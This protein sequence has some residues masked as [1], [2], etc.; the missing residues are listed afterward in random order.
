MKTTGVVRAKLVD[1]RRLPECP[2]CHGGA[3][4]TC[5]CRL[6]VKIDDMVVELSEQHE[7]EILRHGVRPGQTC[8]LQCEDGV[9]NDMVHSKQGTFA[10]IEEMFPKAR[11]EAGGRLDHA[12]GISV[13]VDYGLDFTEQGQ[14][15]AQGWFDAQPAALP[16]S[17]FPWGEVYRN[18]DGTADDGDAGKEEA[19]SKVFQLAGASLVP[20][21]GWVLE[22]VISPG[23]GIQWPRA[24]S[25]LVKTTLVQYFLS[26]SAVE[27]DSLSHL[28][29]IVGVSK[30]RISPLWQEF[31]TRFPGVKAR[32]EKTDKAKLALRKAQLNR[33][34]V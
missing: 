18:L 8:T 11:K 29:A 16:I 7:A 15:D 32:W 5:K 21:L 13:G 10:S 27:A 12:G 24:T 9:V 2:T 6:H 3:D 23:M 31:K 4:F 20:I 33:R 14:A 26:P 25:V 1:P 30:Q 22:P 34:A 17:E 19:M 28:E